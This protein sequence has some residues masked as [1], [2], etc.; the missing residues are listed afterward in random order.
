MAIQL[1]GKKVTIMGLG[2]HGGGIASARYCARQGAAVTVTDLRSAEQLAP[3]VQQLHGLPIQ[4]VLGEHRDEDFID[5]DIVVKNPAVRR[6]NRYL[7][8][9]KRIETDISL[10]LQS[11]GGPII[12]VTGSKGKSTTASAIHWVL[13]RECPAAR[14]GG[15]ITTSPLTFIDD[16]ANGDPVVLELSSFQLGDLTITG[17]WLEGWRFAPEISLLTNI[18]SDHQDYYGAMEP[19]IQDKEV[20][21]A[22]QS[23]SGF[24]V[25]PADDPAG[26]RFAAATAA[27]VFSFSGNNPDHGKIGGYLEGER[28]FSDI[29]AKR[30][31]VVDS[32]N[33]YGGPRINLLAAAIALRAYGIPAQTIREGLSRFPGIA[34]RMELLGERNGV[35]VYNDTAA[36]IPKATLATVSA[37]P[38]PVVLIAGGADKKLDIAAFTEIHEKCAAVVLLEGNASERIFALLESRGLACDGF[39]GNLHDAFTAAIGHAAALGRCA[40]VLSPG[41]ASFNMFNNEFDRGDQFRSIAREWIEGE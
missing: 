8:L 10:F 36:T 39:Y 33:V 6:N 14:L 37:L 35:S 22:H 31:L 17:S 41:A 1:H 32:L 24:A 13:N 29:T 20:I 5:A 28:G 19:Y 30:E 2:L 12:A 4:F 34:H 25:L 38:V 9:A 11:F 3:S 40:V 15:N 18:M 26:Q 21:C 27:R 7:S 23:S 16:L